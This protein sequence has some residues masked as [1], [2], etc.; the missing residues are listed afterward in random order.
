MPF[1]NWKSALLSA[2]CRAAIFLAANLP[3][4]LG[5]GGRAWLTEFLFRTI[6]SGV[7]GSL[8]QRCACRALPPRLWTLAVLGISAVGHALEYLVHRA[9]GTPRIGTALAG[10]ILFTIFSTS[11]HLYV[12]RRNVFTTGPGSQ[13]LLADFAR[14]PGLAADA[15]RS[16]W[17]SRRCI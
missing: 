1:W 9:A 4:G 3:A 16:L 2:N 15:A 17:A 7:L 10:S 5:A 13:S 11:F 8:T 14:L 6:A 12:M